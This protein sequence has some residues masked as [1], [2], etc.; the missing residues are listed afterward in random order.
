VGKWR[1]VTPKWA[2]RGKRI[3]SGKR[4]EATGEWRNLHMRSFVICD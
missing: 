2:E 4:R 1:Y 3:G